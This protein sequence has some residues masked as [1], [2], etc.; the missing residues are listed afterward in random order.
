MQNLGC[1]LR[2]ASS[3]VCPHLVAISSRFFFLPVRTVALCL[4]STFLCCG[5]ESSS[6]RK[7]RGQWVR[8][9]A[10]LL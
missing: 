2:S 8:P 7:Q 3:S 9:R 10:S 1:F 4:G 5:L 6:G